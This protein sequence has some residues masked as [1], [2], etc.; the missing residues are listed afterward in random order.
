MLYIIIII[1]LKVGTSR[2]LLVGKQFQ[3]MAGFDRVSEY[4]N[5]TRVYD[6]QK[7]FDLYFMVVRILLILNRSPQ[8]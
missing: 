4:D 7:A 3:V 8:G 6:F 1:K 5:I 2:E